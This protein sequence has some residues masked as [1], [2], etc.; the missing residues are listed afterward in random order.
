[1]SEVDQE[2]R[3]GVCD[4]CD[5]DEGELCAVVQRD[6]ELATLRARL[7]EA[8]HSRDA[9]KARAL[10]AWEEAAQMV[11]DAEWLDIPDYTRRNIATSFR[12]M[13]RLRDGGQ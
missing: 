13:A 3:C 4:P 5:E 12:N 6:N 9:W 8:E 7:A 11:E 10:A 2:F 1:M